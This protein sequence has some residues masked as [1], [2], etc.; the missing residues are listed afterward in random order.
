MLDE[1]NG[2]GEKRSRGRWVLCEILEGSVGV[3]S[4]GPWVLREAFEVNWVLC[5]TLDDVSGYCMASLGGQWLS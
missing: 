5:D 3:V 1:F 4:V 2:Y